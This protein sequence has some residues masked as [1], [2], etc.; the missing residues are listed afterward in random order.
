M[1]WR[2]VG[3]EDELDLDGLR[4]LLGGVRLF[5]E[6]DSVDNVGLEAALRRLIEEAARD[7][8]VLLER[9]TPLGDAELG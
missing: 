4:R 6:V 5:V 3:V 2:V 9:V 1:R 8:G 7:A